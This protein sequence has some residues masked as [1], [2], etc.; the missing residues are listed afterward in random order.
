MHEPRCGRCGHAYSKHQTRSG[1]LAPFCVNAEPMHKC[2]CGE[3]HVKLCPCPGWVP[4]P[5]G[6]DPRPRGRAVDPVESTYVGESE[7]E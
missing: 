7:L 6:M 4:H 2:G 3:D 5:S 1:E